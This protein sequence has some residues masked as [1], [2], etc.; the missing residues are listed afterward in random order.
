MIIKR[1]NKL[2]HLI[3][4]RA[5]LFIVLAA[6]AL[7][8]FF[9]MIDNVRGVTYDIQLTELS[10]ETIRSSKTVEDTV[11]T[12]IER[13]NA[14]KAV[15]PVYIYKDEVPSQRATFVTTIFDIALEVKKDIAEAE[16]EIPQAEQI[17]M[18]RSGLKDIFDNHQNLILSDA[19]L[20][21]V[22]SASQPNLESARD[23]LATLVEVN[24][25]YPLRKDSLL[26]YRNELESKIRQQPSISE[27]LMSVAIVIGRAAIVETEVLD[28]EKTAIAKQQAKEAVEPTRILQGQ[29]IVQEGEVITREIYRQL[30]LLGM[31]DSEESIKPI[32]GLII[33]IL[34]QMSFLFVLFDR[35]EKDIASKR[36]E[37]LVTII[38]YVIALIM[39]KLIALISTNFDLMI[40]FIFPSALV[41]MLVRVLANDRTASIVTIITAA[42]AGIIFH[43]GLSGI[44]QMDTALYILFGGFA[45]IIFMRSLEKRTDILQAVGIVTLV[46]IVFIA[47][48]ILM[49]QSGYGMKEVAFYVAAAIISGLLSGALMMGLLPYF[50]SAFG[51]LSVVR[52]IELSNPNHPLLKKILTETPGTYHHSIMVANLAEAA[53]EAI[54]ADGLLARV[55]C[56]YHDVGKTRRPLFFIENQMGTN[57]HDT[58]APESSAEIIIA[59]TTDGAE[60]LRK[61]KMPQE[62]IDICLQHHGT[63]TLK[64]F[65]FK[66][67]EEGKELD[68]SVFRYPGPK[69]QTKEA[70]I[71]S[72]AD[73]VEAA[74]R[75]MQHP[76]AEKIQKLVQTIIQDRVQD[77]QFDECD[78]SLKELK[79]IED[80][81]CE[82]LNG[83]FHSRIEYPKE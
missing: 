76:N 52:L 82:T 50:E 27:G 35:T 3:S 10:P 60:L 29:I 25:N 41:T 43:E 12:E 47:F 77:D 73:S 37:L 44:L 38:V 78:I 80:V 45:S 74:V 55:G 4:F 30:E 1:F 83:T 32:A 56:Y 16:E 26:P 75:S 20:L 61:H 62:I 40:A 7:L 19:Q 71:I 57:P 46:N 70:A 31:L 59:H 68:E 14:E 5:L 69:P 36:N 67:K 15:D 18:L 23:A 54:G 65:L 79:K 6:T 53:C 64:F 81:L 42:S 28:E 11:K 66:A 72:I 24:L 34:L 63:S 49:G 17:K 13:E 2:I 33:L 21:N 22:L 48:Y 8:Q 58:M 51:L 39:M 9:L